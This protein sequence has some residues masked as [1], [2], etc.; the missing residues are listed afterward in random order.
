ME[1]QG[2]TALQLGLKLLY[3]R[4][5]FFVILL[6]VLVVLILNKRRELKKDWN[7]LS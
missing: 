4:M 7:S 2:S 1:E 3:M 5:E 6:L